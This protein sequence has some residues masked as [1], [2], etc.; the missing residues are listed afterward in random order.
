MR[1]RARGRPRSCPGHGGEAADW[2]RRMQHPI[3]KRLEAALD[4]D[5][6]EQRQNER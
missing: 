2:R 4:P 1:T 6:G 3:A 5:A